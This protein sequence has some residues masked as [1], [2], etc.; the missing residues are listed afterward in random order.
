MVPLNQCQEG[1]R[2]R[3]VSLCRDSR[4]RCRLCAMGLTPGVEARVCGRGGGCRLRVRGGEVCLGD[5]LAR[6]VMV[7]E[8]P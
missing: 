5:N 6:E 4:C 3:I 2:V 1:S 7:K 8:L